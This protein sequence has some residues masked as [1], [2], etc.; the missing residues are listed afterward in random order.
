MRIFIA[1]H[2]VCLG[3]VFFRA[4]TLGDSLQILEGILGFGQSY[5]APFFDANIL[6]NAALGVALLL[7]VQVWQE[8]LG[9]VRESLARAPLAVRFAAVYLLVFA[10]SLF[11]VEAGAQFIYFQF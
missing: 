8:R 4:E 10:I 5:A 3:W 6:A 9:S 2:L 11:G 1:F 7:A